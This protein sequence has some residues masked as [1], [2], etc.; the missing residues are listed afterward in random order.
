MDRKERLPWDEMSNMMFMLFGKQ[1]DWD[2]K[3]LAEKTNQPI[4]CNLFHL[5]I[6]AQAYIRECLSKLCVQNRKGA[7]KGTWSLKPEYRVGVDTA[8]P[9]EQ[10]PPE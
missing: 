4:V 7:N 8:T 2:A 9:M 1:P 3:S 10:Q 6:I 5:S